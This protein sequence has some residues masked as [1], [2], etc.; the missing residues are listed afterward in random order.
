MH[1]RTK[2]NQLAIVTTHPPFRICSKSHKILNRF[3]DPMSIYDH[4]I[5]LETEVEPIYMTLLEP[6][7]NLRVVDF[8]D[9][10]RRFSIEIAGVA[11]ES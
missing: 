7:Q 10:F 8:Q 11:Y 5:F 4:P 9:Y 3:L 6:V 1:K 2:V